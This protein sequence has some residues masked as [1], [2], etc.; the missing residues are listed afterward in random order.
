MS[1]V[2]LNV[3]VESAEVDVEVVDVPVVDV[4]VVETSV[5]ALLVVGPTGPTGLT[6]PT[7][8]V[9]PEGPQGVP[10]PVG[11]QGLK[12]DTGDAG[13]VGP[14]GPAGVAGPKGDKGDKG[15]TGDQG[16]VGPTGATGAAG[17]A[18]PEGPT[19]PAGPQ[20]P[21]GL[22]GDKGDTG[23]VGPAG[24]A[25]PVGASG[26][27]GA[28]GP[29]GPQGLK[30]DTGDTGP[31]GPAGADGSDGL[32]AY[33]LA[34][35]DGF[36]GTESAWLASLVGPTG[37][38]GA[39]GPTGPQGL[40]GDPGAD[41]ADGATGPQGPIGL[42]G[43]QGPAGATGGVGPAGDTGPA[44]PQGPQGDPGPVGPAG[45][46]G[47]DLQV[48]GVGDYPLPD[49]SAHTGEVWVTSSDGQFW[50]SSGSFWSW[51][52]VRGPEG[53]AGPAG[54]SLPDVIPLPQVSDPA[55]TADLQL[56]SKR[57]AN[58]SM[59]KAVQPSGRDYP[60]Q[61][62][63]FQNAI[64]LVTPNQTSSVQAVGGNVTSVGT[65]STQVPATLGSTTF[66]FAT[67]FASAATANIT[68]GTGMRD[69]QVRHGGVAGLVG[70]FFYFARV[71]FSDAA[72]ASGGVAATGF[73]F[74]CGATSGT[75]AAIAGSDSPTGDFAGFHI[76]DN[77]TLQETTFQF[78]TRNNTATTRVDTGVPFVA[79]NVYDFYVFSRPGTTD[80]IW[81]RADNITTGMTYEGSQ[82]ATL[83]RSTV[84]L[85]VGAQLGTVN[86]LARNLRI[87]RLYCESDY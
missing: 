60:F 24:P 61:P 16:L 22:K 62:A 6:G 80:E 77:G 11:P 48:D 41:G 58:R 56:Y 52:D 37:A 83:P 81:W 31:A 47:A 7:G 66:P 49:A 51:V 3:V 75:M 18:G 15:D 72:Y 84:N 46:D 69:L 39:T 5:A 86:A 87:A 53:P 45:A 36:V 34:V 29:V 14:V 79:R 63:F 67:N 32:S 64:W 1:E 10:G 9:G 26:P 20:G 59:L 42:T 19:G 27:A 71:G 2:E 50:V 33:E 43:P 55:P 65:V 13:P 23:S 4:E 40:Q 38:T 57:I 8:A 85:R 17:P 74:F 76:I 44:G 78:A 73:R 68:C 28:T 54:G 70:G 25:G 82:T 21:Q 12:G 30:G 35:A